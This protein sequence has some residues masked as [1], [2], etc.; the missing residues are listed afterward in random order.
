[1][2]HVILTNKHDDRTQD[3]KSRYMIHGHDCQVGSLD[4]VLT[5]RINAEL[6]KKKSPVFWIY[7]RTIS[8]FDNANANNNC[9]WKNKEEK[10]K[11]KKKPSVSRQLCHR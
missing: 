8:F 2:N 5:C 6:E 10:K 3:E 9:C 4:M 7:M 11:K 1:M